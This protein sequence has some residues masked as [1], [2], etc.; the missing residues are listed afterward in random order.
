MLIRAIYLTAI[1][2]ASQPIMAEVHLTNLLSDHAVL[3]R[4]SAIHIWGWANP[5]EV[6]TVRFHGQTV[7]TRG[8]ENGTWEVWLS[9]EPAGGP[10]TLSVFGNATASAVE[11]KDILVGDVWIA[12]GQS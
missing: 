3:Q 10:F 9:P 5:T 8:D 2:C 11:R 12:S 7:V 1:L 4:E 6:V